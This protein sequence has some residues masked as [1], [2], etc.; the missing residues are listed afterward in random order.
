MFVL[1]FKV[2]EMIRP[3]LL[4][5][6]GV[7]SGSL[8]HA[9]QPSDLLLVDETPP[10]DRG[11]VV[12][13]EGQAVNFY[14]VFY[15]GS[16]SAVSQRGLSNIVW[17]VNDVLC[18]E[19]VNAGVPDHMDDRF[20]FTTDR[21]TVTNGAFHD[22]KIEV[23]GMDR[24]GVATN[25]IWTVRVNNVRL[26]QFITW[27]SFFSE[28]TL[29]IADFPGGAI[30]SSGM[31]VSYASL[32]EEVAQ[33][34]N[35]L[36]HLVGAGE[37]TIVASQAGSEDY[38]KAD[39]AFQSLTVKAMLTAEVPGGG[40]TVAGTGAYLPGAT[41]RLTAVPSKGFYFQQWEDGSHSPVR[42]LITSN[43]N[44]RVTAAFSSRIPDPELGS[45]LP[46]SG[47][48]GTSFKLDIPVLSDCRPKVSVSG[49]P[50]GLS[51]NVA[52]HRIEGYPR[53]ACSNKVVTITI[54]NSK[55]VSVSQRFVLTVASLPDWVCGEYSGI[56]SAF[57]TH[58]DS[59]STLS[60]AKNGKISLKLKSGD[61][62][63][64]L[65]ADGFQSNDPNFELGTSL[66]D[67]KKEWTIGLGVERRDFD[68]GTEAMRVTSAYSRLTVCD[69][70]AD[71]TLNFC[72]S[73]ELS[74]DVSINPSVASLLDSR[75]A[76][77]Y[78]AT[79]NG[80][81][82]YGSGYLA[83]TVDKRGN[84]RAAGKLADGTAVSLGGRLLFEGGRVWVPLLTTP[85]D[86]KGGFFFC[87]L[88]WPTPEDG[89]AE[90]SALT[91]A[92][93]WTSRNPCATDQYGLGFSRACDISGGWFDKA[94]DLYAYYKSDVFSL[95]SDDDAYLPALHFGSRTD[96]PV[97]WNPSCVAIYPVFNEKAQMVGLA[98][99]SGTLPGLC[100][101]E[102]SEFANLSVLVNRASGVFKGSYNIGVQSE[103]AMAISK[104]RVAYEGVLTPVRSEGEESIA[105]RAFALLMTQGTMTNVTGR[106]RAYMTNHSLDLRLLTLPKRS[107]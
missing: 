96:E 56:V 86:Y 36:I 16:G 30:A 51:C 60:V 9:A 94:G 49:L 44:R 40:G 64:A 6:I 105:G 66:K 87:S 29:G 12:V 76:G 17:R 48:V 25:G 4:L 80:G 107:E 42:E 103:G 61:A 67:G 75:Y 50:L 90:L 21:S 104:Q 34:R 45:I 1:S 102:E 100:S 85:A 52:T 26:N 91:G 24:W 31:P 47:M 35:G 77:Y 13:S 54:A 41:V 88:D 89:R 101:A 14:A 55:R 38:C 20:T 33:I 68:I 59:L 65:T 72:A 23:T 106:S 53:V 83:L 79:V 81:V 22:F 98:T 93:R 28:K 15:Y 27:E 63:L 57:G 10:V 92:A 78:T 19:T 43:V 82:S 71:G 7:L 97:Y 46:Q 37:T 8:L 62:T 2:L 5:Q 99:A 69:H 70:G 18:R 3:L 11:I 95:A 84:V 39:D 58:S 32:N 74:R 73:G